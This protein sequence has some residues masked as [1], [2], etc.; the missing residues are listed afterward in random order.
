MNGYSRIVSELKSIVG[1]DY[2]V[3]LP[4]DLIVFE[5]D[6]SVDKALPSAVVL[7]ATTGEVSAVVR[8]AQQTRLDDLRLRRALRFQRDRQTRAAVGRVAEP[9]LCDRLVAQAAPAQVIERR[10]SGR[11]AELRLEP[12]GRRF[13]DVI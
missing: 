6:G 4:E 2:V 11:F 1:D 13:D 5:Y 3:D 12:S 7:P 9:E 8:A 10:L